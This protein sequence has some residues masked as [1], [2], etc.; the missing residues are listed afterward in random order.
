M[1]E[2]VHYAFIFDKKVTFIVKDGRVFEEQWIIDYDEAY[3]ITEDCRIF[4]SD[5]SE[6]III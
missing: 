6:V 5:I 2:L 1:R 4:W 3:I